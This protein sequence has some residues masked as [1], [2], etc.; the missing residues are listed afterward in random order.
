MSV[1]P[2][3][4]YCLRVCAL[5]NVPGPGSECLPMVLVHLTGHTSCHRNL[6]VWKQYQGNFFPSSLDFYTLSQKF[7]EIC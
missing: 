3:H 6:T 4:G 5:G 1:F 2:H 7:K